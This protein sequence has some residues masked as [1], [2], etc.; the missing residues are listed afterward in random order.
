MR[1]GVFLD[2]ELADHIAAGKWNKSKRQNFAKSHTERESETNGDQEPA[3]WCHAIRSR[4]I[5]WS[6]RAG[7]R[8]S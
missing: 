4:R 7:G 3:H 5:A 8:L 2:R 6:L 1:V